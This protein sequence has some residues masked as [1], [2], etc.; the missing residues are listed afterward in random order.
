MRSLID[1]I[2][3]L[4]VLAILAMIP[5]VL[6]EYNNYIVQKEEWDNIPEMSNI[7]STKDMKI[8]DVE[9]DKF[10]SNSLFVETERAK[11]K[12]G[13]L[14]LVVPVMGVDDNVMDGTDNSSLKHGPGLYTVA[15]MPRPRC[16]VN[17][18]MAGHRAGYGRYGNLFKKIEDVGLGDKLYLV[19]KEWIYIYEYVDTKVVEPD[20]ISVLYTQ[21]FTCL[22]LTSCHPLGGNKQRIVLRAKLIE[23]VEYKEDYEYT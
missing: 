18:S 12:S 16:N 19:S 1:N 5:I 4:F 23:V 7:P 14:R 6:Y 21:G 17:T 20:D 22:T 2:K 11:F 9:P 10:P 8:L 13:D 3:I 15:Q